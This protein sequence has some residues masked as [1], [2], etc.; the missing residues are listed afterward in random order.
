[1]GTRTR[2]QPV[3]ADS[4]LRPHGVGEGREGGREGVSA[5]ARTQLVSA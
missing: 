4:K 1:V 3:R 5:S 2:T